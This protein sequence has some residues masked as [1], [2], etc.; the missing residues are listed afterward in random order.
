MSDVATIYRLALNR[1][2]KWRVLLAGWQV[3]TRVKGD[4]EGDAIRD[5]REATLL[6]RADVSALTSLL[7][8][9]GVFT[10][11][12]MQRQTAI[13]ADFLSEAL[14]RRFPGVTATDDG[15]SFDPRAAETLKGFKP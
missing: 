14:S 11:E 10:P 1:L 7:I 5:H 4:P 8:D 6:L 2:A 3:G 13:E 12:D 15:L 9:K